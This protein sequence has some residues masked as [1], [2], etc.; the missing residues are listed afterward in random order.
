MIIYS[1]WIWPVRRT[2]YLFKKVNKY[3]M[4][5][6]KYGKQTYFTCEN[7]CI[8]DPVGILFIY[9]QKLKTLMICL[10]NC[11]HYSRLKVRIKLFSGI[12]SKRSKMPREETSK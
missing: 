3:F 5:V 7:N 1:S 8:P 4:F 12:D 6:L 10:E 2:Q 11:H 9:L